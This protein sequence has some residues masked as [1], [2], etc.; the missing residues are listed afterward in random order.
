MLY[1][2]KYPKAKIQAIQ[3]F[4][5]YIMLEVVLRAH[6]IPDDVF[7]ESLV[8][9][10]YVP[11][12]RD[13]NSKYILT[14]IARMFSISKKLDSIHLK[15][16]RKAVYE[17]NKIE[18]LCK[19]AYTPIRYKYLMTVFT[20][21]Y[22]T[23]M[24]DN[25]KVFC[26]N[27][28]EKCL[29]LKPIYDRYGKIK[30]YHDMLV[31][32]DDRCHNCGCPS[33]ITMHAKTVRNAFDHYLAKQ[34]YP[35][36]SVNFKNLVPSCYTCN[37]LY[38][39]AKD[40]LEVRGKRKKAF[41]PFTNEHYEI[42]FQI[43]FKPSVTYDKTL[44]PKDFDIKCSCLGHQEEAENWMRVYNIQEQYKA[45]CCSMTFQSYLSN[46]LA[47][48]K[49]KNKTVE[50]CL[51]MLEDNIDADMNFLKVPFYRAALASLN[52]I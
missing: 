25:I 10:K 9:S 48:V 24:I 27:L 6:N 45:K 51:S 3:S 1:P 31:G 2:Y 37:S 4:V 11:I 8:I 5:N 19:G 49:I 22:E 39:K 14:P 18:E 33:L 44:Q 41:Y 13:I 32:D 30:E 47:E 28:Y 29:T 16:L 20:K 50:E 46:I 42:K 15:L 36:V 35:F 40:I 17:N 23:E 43:K 21:D 52:I 12:I 34:T 7:S 26:K 38:K